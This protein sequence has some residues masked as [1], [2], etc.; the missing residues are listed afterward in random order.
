MTFEVCEGCGR[1][2]LTG[3]RSVRLAR[4]EQSLTA[5]VLCAA[6]LRDGGFLRAA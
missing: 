1:T 2:L 4:D 6:K 3:E 5:C